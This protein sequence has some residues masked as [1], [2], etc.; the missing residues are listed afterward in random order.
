GETRQIVVSVQPRQA[1]AVEFCADALVGGQVAARGCAT[2]T[3]AG[4]QPLDVNIRTEA[5]ASQF[6]IGDSVNFT[7]TLTNRGSVPLTG[8]ELRDTFDEGLQHTTTAQR[9]LKLPMSGGLAANE[10][11]EIGLVFQI[12]RAGR[13]CHTVTA[14]TAQGYSATRQACIDVAGGTGEAAP[15]AIDV[16]VSGPP[17]INVGQR[18]VFLVEVTNNGAAALAN[19]EALVDFDGDSL[20]VSDLMGFAN[21]NSR[22]VWRIARIE[23]RQ[24]LRTQIEFTARGAN[25]G[26][27][28]AINVNERD[29]LVGGAR[30]PVAVIAGAAAVAQGG[31]LKLAVS[32]G[33]N[34]ISAGDELVYVVSVQN[35]GGG[36]ESDVVVEVLLPEGITLPRVQA[37]QKSN[38]SGRTIRFEP[39]AALRPL[40]TERFTIRARSGGA[41]KYVLQAS[42]TSRN[43]PQ[44]QTQRAETT[45]IPR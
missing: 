17:T 37:L 35:V 4:D 3:I 1:G 20:E 2:T 42:V 29:Q 41:G 11:R 32:S 39:I 9:E 33:A 36:V 45:V 14:S 23:P 25:P 40:A 34:S 26:S 8:I 44:P 24:T 6:R 43:F 30:A 27:F 28:V 21:V 7:V 19:L 12:T 38:T 10:S 5:G 22:A 16:R 13:L 18:G 31:Q 15:G